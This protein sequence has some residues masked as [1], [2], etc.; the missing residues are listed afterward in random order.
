M[1]HKIRKY[2]ER[3][4]RPHESWRYIKFRPRLKYFTGNKKTEWEEYKEFLREQG[5]KI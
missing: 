1:S 4:K 5:W 3:D 2:S